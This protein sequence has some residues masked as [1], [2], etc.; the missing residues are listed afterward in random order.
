MSSNLFPVL[1]PKGYSY[2]CGCRHLRHLF[3]QVNHSIVVVYV[4][5][6]RTTNEA[7]LPVTLV[8][9]SVEFPTELPTDSLAAES[10]QTESANTRYQLAARCTHTNAALLVWRVPLFYIVSVS[11]KMRLVLLRQRTPKGDE[12]GDS[13][14]RLK[15]KPYESQSSRYWRQPQSHRT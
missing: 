15:R 3:C 4:W 14:L 11:V 8:R 1:N 7:S 5:F 2:E 13:P 6:L 12:Q 9:L 10:A